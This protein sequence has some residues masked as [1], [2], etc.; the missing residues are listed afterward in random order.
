ME[1]T[2]NV[3]L[4]LT[5]AEINPKSGQ[6]EERWKETISAQPVQITQNPNNFPH[7]NNTLYSQRQAKDSFP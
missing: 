2:E 1:S 4:P 7:R 5:E 6:P 3:Y